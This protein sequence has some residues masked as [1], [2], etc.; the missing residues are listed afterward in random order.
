[1]PDATALAGPL[2][3]EIQQTKSSS[4]VDRSTHWYPGSSRLKSPSWL[5]RS[6]RPKGITKKFI[7][8]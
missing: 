2:V 5:D 1:M 6:Y 3:P 8:L 7:R 4:C